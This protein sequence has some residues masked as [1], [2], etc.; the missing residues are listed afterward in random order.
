MDVH[1][2]QALDN[3]SKQLDEVAALRLSFSSTA[4]LAESTEVTVFDDTAVDAA[5]AADGRGTP[6]SNVR[7]GVD[8][9]EAAT[10]VEAVDSPPQAAIPLL[11][12][13]E[14]GEDMMEL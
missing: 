12:L 4:L 13:E 3:V 6:T 2:R 1:R 10:A 5:V 7:M 14:A 11:P 9:S 8:A